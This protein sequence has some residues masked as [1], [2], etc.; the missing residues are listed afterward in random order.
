[1]ADPFSDFA[2]TFGAREPED[3]PFDP[4]TQQGQDAAGLILNAFDR[5]S[6]ELYERLPPAHRRMFLERVAAPY[7]TGKD[8]ECLRHLYALDY[9]RIPPTPREFMESSDYMG[10]YCNSELFPAWKPHLLKILDPASRIHE[11][12]ITGASGLGKTTAACLIFG[13]LIT[14]ILCL[15]EASSFYGLAPRSKIYFGFYAFH[16]AMASQVGIYELRDVMLGPS[17]F[18]REIY[19]FDKAGKEYIRWQGIGKALEVIVGAAEMHALGKALFAVIA[20]ELNYFKQGVNTEDAA[21]KLVRELS[22]RLETRFVEEGGSIPG[23]A[24]YIS[25]TRTTSDYLEQ[26]IRDKKGAHGVYIV[27]GPRWA[28]NTLGYHRNKKQGFD[29]TTDP[30]FRVY[31]GTETTDP[32]ILDQVVRQPDGTYHVFPSSEDVGGWEESLVIQVPV[33][34]HGAFMDDIHG[35]LRN[36]AD[37]PTG[38]FTPFFPRRIVVQ[39]I[40]DE[41]LPFPF[42]K[43]EIPCYE[44]MSYRLQD[45][46]DHEMVTKISMGRY[47]PIRNPGSPRYIHLDLSQGGDRTGFAMVHPSG[48]EVVDRTPEDIGDDPSRVG[49]TE[50]VKNVECDFYVALTCGP[51]GESIDYRKIRVFIDWLRK[52]GFHIVKI[53]ADQYMSF[54]HLQRLREAKFKADLQSTDKTSQPY[55]DT[56]QAMNEARVKVPWPT[57]LLEHA[58]LEVAAAS[59][60]DSPLPLDLAVGQA[61][62]RVILYNELTGLE[63]DVQRDKI[64]HRSTNP[65]GTKGSK[66]VSDALAG[67]VFTCLADKDINPSNA[68]A[69]PTTPKQSFNARY[70]RYLSQVN[71]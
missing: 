33:I 70:N 49:N 25:Q 8:E 38:A 54:D 9:E 21:R 3:D 30:S 17:P 13:Y 18:F 52:C 51:H 45:S 50:V 2:N 62:T 53:T 68:R 63:H 36:L 16:K 34:H 10:H 55:R 12:D 59:G 22:R 11:T 64:D 58:R 32:K 26:R 28:F 65:D 44:G 37:I 31:V 71:Y 20:D 56:R 40:F 48:H 29:P 35:A 23:M 7:L 24:I 6:R 5:G 4:R 46:F 27:R 41:T 15:R 61:L 47:Q 42:N 67:A 66:D 57:G 43:Q 1:M 69:Y 19:P 60:S 39:R 14:R